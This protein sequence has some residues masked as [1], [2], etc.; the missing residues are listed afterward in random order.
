MEIF[1]VEGI[2]G[3]C[4]L[5]ELLLCILTKGN[6]Y[7]PYIEPFMINASPFVKL[8]CEIFAAVGQKN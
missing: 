2:S 1:S 6:T 7:S 8:L 4:I 5:G 3:H